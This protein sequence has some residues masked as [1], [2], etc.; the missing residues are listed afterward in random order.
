MKAEILSGTSVMKSP[1]LACVVSRPLSGSSVARA[2]SRG[3]DSRLSGF[4]VR[5]AHVDDAGLASFRLVVSIKFAMR[6]S[7]GVTWVGEGPHKLIHADST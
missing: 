7:A 3:P 2:V 1:M 6:Y 4:P 5:P